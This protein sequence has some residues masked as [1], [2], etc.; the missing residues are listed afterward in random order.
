MEEPEK[1]HTVLK[2]IEESKSPRTDFKLAIITLYS[3]FSSRI[4]LNK[5]IEDPKGFNISFYNSKKSK[6][7]SETTNFYNALILKINYKDSP[8]VSCNLFSNGAIG[9]TGL[10]SYDTAYEIIEYIYNLLNTNFSDA[11]LDSNDFK[12][13]D[14]YVGNM[15]FYYKLNTIINQEELKDFI[16]LSSNK[17]SS[18]SSTSTSSSTSSWKLAVFNSN[19]Y[20]AVKARL[21]SSDDDDE[22]DVL[23]VSFFRTGTVSINCKK[24]SEILRTFNEINTL[25]NKFTNSK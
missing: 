7:R 5:I 16:N 8:G 24:T 25:I 20:Y 10:K 14:V 19:N 15:K 11:I 21:K 13:N 18:S 23:K 2:Y 9:I 4:L 17:F 1:Y 3:T 6:Q 22:E 12:I